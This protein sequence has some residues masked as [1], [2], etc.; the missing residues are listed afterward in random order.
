ML[1]DQK[2]MKDN[3]NAICIMKK[4]NYWEIALIITQFWWTDEF[5]TKIRALKL[6]KHYEKTN[7][8]FTPPR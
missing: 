6:M 4:M 5:M 8:A 2:S 7:R 3:L 1:L